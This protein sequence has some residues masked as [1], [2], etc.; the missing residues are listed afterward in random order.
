MNFLKKIGNKYGEP[1]QIE[2]KIGIGDIPRPSS[3]FLNEPMVGE[4]NL[5]P[6]PIANLK[7]LPLTN[8]Q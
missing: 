3:N 1:A 7:C 4:D 5:S 6:I 2:R 8:R